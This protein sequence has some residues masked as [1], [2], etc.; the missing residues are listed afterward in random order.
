[1][2]GI[3]RRHTHRLVARGD[4][5]YELALFDSAGHDRPP[6]SPEIRGRG[7]LGI[8]PEFDIFRRR[9]GAVAAPAFVGE[10]RA[11]V[12]VE[13]YLAGGNSVLYGPNRYVPH[14]VRQEE[15]CE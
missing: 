11:D 3:N 15:R 1:M 7:G 4:P 10:Y 2:A 6:T 9:V 13:I 8:Q 5:A 14:C 12:T